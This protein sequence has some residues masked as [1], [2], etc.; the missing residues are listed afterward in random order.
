MAS[1]ERLDRLIK[2]A[3]KFQHAAVDHIKDMRERRRCDCECNC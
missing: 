2:L 1:K 3:K